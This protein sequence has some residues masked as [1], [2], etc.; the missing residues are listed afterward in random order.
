MSQMVPLRIETC[1]RPAKKVKIVADLACDNLATHLSMCR[2]RPCQFVL[3]HDK[4]AIDRMGVSAVLNQSHDPRE[5]HSD[6]REVWERP[7]LR[8]LVANEAQGGVG[9]LDDGNCSG[10]AGGNNLNHSF[11]Y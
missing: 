2:I 10:G 8:R 6:S 5:Q 11:C 1:G 7:A 4:K 9:P 3:V